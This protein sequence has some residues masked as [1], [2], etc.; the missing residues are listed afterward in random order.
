MAKSEISV[1]RRTAMSKF[2]NLKKLNYIPPVHKLI[3]N[4]I[5]DNKPADMP[6][7]ELATR[8]GLTRPGRQATPI[9][10]MLRAGT[11]R[12]PI[13]KVI[14][15]ADELNIDRRELFISY[16]RGAVY[17]SIMKCDMPKESED[18]ETEK[19]REAREVAEKTFKLQFLRYEKTWDSLASLLV[20]NYS[21]REEPFVTAFREVEEEVGHEIT[22]DDA[23]VEDFKELLRNQYAI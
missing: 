22:L 14:V 10:S 21:E 9:M 4:A 2:V 7:Y 12:L 6:L 16:L 23:M 18:H 3:D 20:F 5:V 19:E 15:V 13:D 11:M 1:R 8:C 17:S